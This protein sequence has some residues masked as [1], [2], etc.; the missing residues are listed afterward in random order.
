MSRLKTEV[1]ALRTVAPL[2]SDDEE[3]SN[4]NESPSTRWPVSPVPVQ[5]PQAVNASPRPERSAEW[6]EKAQGWP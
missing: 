4:D 3:F 2:L 5:V 6:K 1:E